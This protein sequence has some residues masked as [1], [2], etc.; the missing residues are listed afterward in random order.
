MTRIVCNVGVTL[1]LRNNDR[2]S[3]L[4]DKIEISE[5]FKGTRKQA[6]GLLAFYRPRP[7]PKQNSGFG[8]SNRAKPNF[9]L[10]VT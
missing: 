1:P 2:L 4:R 9:S 10:S 8:L 6:S 5:K 7:K 3:Y